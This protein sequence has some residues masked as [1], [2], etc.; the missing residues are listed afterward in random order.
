MNMLTRRATRLVATLCTA[1]LLPMLIIGCDI[2]GIGT[3]VEDTFDLI[4]QLPSVETTFAGQIVDAESGQIIDQQNVDVVIQGPDKSA[5]MDPILFEPISRATVE[6]GFLDLALKEEI[7]P[8]A[9]A[10]VRFSVVASADGYITN[11]KSISVADTGKYRFSIRL[12]A[13]ERP[14]SGVSIKSDEPSGSADASGTVT[15]AQTVTTD[16][17]AETGGQAAITVA[18]GTQITDASGQPLQGALSS[19]VAYYA[20]Q[21]ED[22]L[23]SFPGGFDEVTVRRADGSE[24]SGGT[25]VSG[26]FVSVELRDGAGREADQ[27]SQPV[28]VSVSIPAETI[29]PNTGQPVQSG[30]VVPLWS[31]DEDNGVW[32]EEGTTEM[33]SAGGVTLRGPDAQGN[34]TA[35]F[36]APHFSYWNVGWFTASGARCQSGLTFNVSGNESGAALNYKLVGP[37]Y[38]TEFESDDSEITVGNFPSSIPHATLKAKYEGA[39][40]GAKRVEAPCGK[41]SN[42]PLSGMPSS[43]E[44]VTVKL[45][46]DI[47]CDDQQVRPSVDFRYR[48]AGTDGDWNTG[49]L[50]NGNTT[51]SGLVLGA[52]YDVSVTYNDDGVQKTVTETVTVEGEPD[53]D[54][55]IHVDRSFADIDEVCENV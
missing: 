2:S 7:T 52:D 18:Q 35:Q 21:N 48:R 28:G 42:F 27:F 54:G 31:F 45:S 50:E 30:D 43:E 34:L 36:E 9:A 40:V 26:S 11:S 17:E 25:F 19:T 14:P 5:V 12:V 22:A 33:K 51:V 13:E 4:V 41:S 24:A 53:E 1:A 39:E 15:E 55:V 49:T 47:T 38:I 6:S 46:V 37:G 3:E 8:T 23:A 10:P 20:N 32:V 29:N 16:P 44:L